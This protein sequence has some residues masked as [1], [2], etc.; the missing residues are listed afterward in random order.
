VVTNA[1]L[2]NGE[3][4]SLLPGTTTLVYATGTVT[5]LNGF[6]DI[7]NATATIYRSGVAGG[8]ACSVDNNN[9]YR[10]EPG[11]CQFINCSGNSCTVQCEANVQ[12]YA[13]PTDVS[14]LFEGEE[15]LAFI[16]AEDT[17][18]GY[19]FAS[20]LGVELATLRAISVTGAINYGSLTANSDTGSFNASTSVL[21]LGNVEADLEVTG[22]DLTDGGASVIPVNEQKFATTTFTYSACGAICRLLSSTTPVAL[23]VELAKPVV[24][25]PAVQDDIYWGI[26]I[27]FGINSAP[28]QGINL[29]TPVSP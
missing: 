29:F 24:V 2:N 8:A 22:S 21:N 23:D 25:S 14:S 4:I 11:Q 9:C 26:F 17:A 13:E 1:T 10:S 27:P 19:G 18:A 5:D 15:W 28:H 6:A 16:E 20:A 3:T 7:T 12:Y